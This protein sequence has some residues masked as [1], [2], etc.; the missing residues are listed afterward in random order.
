M[1]NRFLCYY[2]N[3]PAALTYYGENKVET[4]RANISLTN[5]SEMD[6]TL[7]TVEE[8]TEIVRILDSLFAKEQQAKEYAEVVLE[9]IDLLKNPSSPAPPAAN[10]APTTPPKHPP[11]NC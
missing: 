1:V 3:S 8:Q 4:A 5:I 10:W 9:K 6:I 7:P 11:W 2:L